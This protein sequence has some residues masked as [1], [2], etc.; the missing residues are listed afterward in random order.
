V[1]IAVTGGELRTQPAL[2]DSGVAG[3]R[4]QPGFARRDRIVEDGLQAPDFIAASDE[5]CRVG[6]FGLA[7]QPLVDRHG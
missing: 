2:A 4:H 5:R 7:S 6:R 1:D 3:D